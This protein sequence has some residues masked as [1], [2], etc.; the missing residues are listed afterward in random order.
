MRNVTDDEKTPQDMHLANMI[1]VPQDDG[2]GFH[3][4]ESDVIRA[5]SDN[6]FV[7]DN[8]AIV[9]GAKIH[10]GDGYYGTSD[11]PEVVIEKIVVLRK[12]R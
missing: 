4:I 11:S 7:L 12:K 6:R 9:H 2:S 5:V 1:R 10:D 3:Y 8:G